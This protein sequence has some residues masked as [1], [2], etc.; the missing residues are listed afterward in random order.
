MFHSIWEFEFTVRSQR[1][2]G[3]RFPTHRF[4]L[5]VILNVWWSTGRFSDIFEGIVSALAV[6]ASE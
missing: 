3:F 2:G 6:S 5:L 4:I 1:Q